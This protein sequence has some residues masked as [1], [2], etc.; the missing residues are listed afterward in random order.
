VSES[1]STASAREQRRSIDETLSWIA[2]QADRLGN[3]QRAF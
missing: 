3:G 2:V 1:T